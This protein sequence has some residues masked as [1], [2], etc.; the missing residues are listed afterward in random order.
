MT[1]ESETWRSIDDASAEQHI[2]GDVASKEGLRLACATS[3]ALTLSITTPSRRSPCRQRTARPIAIEAWA[4][5]SERRARG[6]S[7]IPKMMLRGRT[8]APSCTREPRAEW[9]SRF[10]VRQPVGCGRESMDALLAE[11]GFTTMPVPAR[12]SSSHRRRRLR[13]GLWARLE[14]R[15]GLRGIKPV[16][17]AREAREELL[18]AERRYGDE[19]PKLRI[20][21]LAAIDE[22]CDR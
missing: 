3:T 22:A 5:E 7:L 19:R 9:S 1:C 12:R 6:R 10:G 20:A 2:I 14:L 13:F 16:R 18:E 21:F 4:R 11:P 15:D 17:L 8:F